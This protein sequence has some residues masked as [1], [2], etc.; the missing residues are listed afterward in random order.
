MKLSAAIPGGADIPVQ[1]H[2]AI[3]GWHGQW[4]SIARGLLSFCLLSFCLSPVG[5]TFLSALQNL[6]EHK[7]PLIAQNARISLSFVF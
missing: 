4:Y 3:Q 2:P 1:A 5:R 6:S 7:L